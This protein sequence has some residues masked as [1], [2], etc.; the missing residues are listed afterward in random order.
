MLSIIQTKPVPECNTDANPD[1]ERPQTSCWAAMAQRRRRSG[2]SFGPAPD[3][4]AFMPLRDFW[5]SIHFKDP[6]GRF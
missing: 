2:F 4:W 1:E 6:C 5:S 3:N